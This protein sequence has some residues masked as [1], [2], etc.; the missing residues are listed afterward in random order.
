[1]VLCEFTLNGNESMMNNIE[2][3]IDIRW[4]LRWQVSI[5]GWCDPEQSVSA[6]YLPMLQEF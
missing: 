5:A 6:A 4:Q 3:H 2:I 1:M